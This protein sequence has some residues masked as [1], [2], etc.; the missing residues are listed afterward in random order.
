MKNDITQN[1]HGTEIIIIMAISL[2]IKIAHVY[3][4]MYI[5]KIL[6]VRVPLIILIPTIMV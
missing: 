6:N 2:F 1:S 3:V 4:S 5:Y